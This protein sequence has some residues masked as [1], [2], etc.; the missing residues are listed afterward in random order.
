LAWGRFNGSVL[1]ISLAINTYL[2]Y[3]RADLKGFGALFVRKDMFKTIVFLPDPATAG[4]ARI[5]GVDGFGVLCG[6]WKTW[7]EGDPGRRDTVLLPFLAED[8]HSICA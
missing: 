8:A 5:H 7:F 1:E 6:P 4:Q 2:H 3:I